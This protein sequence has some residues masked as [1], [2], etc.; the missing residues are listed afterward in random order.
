MNDYVGLV[1]VGCV[2]DSV[3]RHFKYAQNFWNGALRREKM[4]LTHPTTNSSRN[5]KPTSTEYSANR[6]CKAFQSQQA[7]QAFQAMR[8]AVHVEQFHLR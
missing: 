7:F 3:T 6:A 8:D 5:R 4:R 1:E 2:S